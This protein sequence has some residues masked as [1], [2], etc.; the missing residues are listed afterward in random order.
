MSLWNIP[1]LMECYGP[2]NHLWKV[3]YDGDKLS[4]ELKHCLKGGLND[5]WHWNQLK[6][7]LAEDVM[8]LIELPWVIEVPNDN[9]S[10]PKEKCYKRYNS[11]MNFM[12]DYVK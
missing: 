3:G 6:N 2:I 10:K 9:E 11:I 12:Q 4:Q 1:D 7:I 8:K 5:N